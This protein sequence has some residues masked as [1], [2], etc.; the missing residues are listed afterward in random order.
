MLRAFTY[1]L[2]L[3]ALP[4]S[5]ANTEPVALSEQSEKLLQGDWCLS[6]TTWDILENKTNNTWSFL[7][8]R[9]Y[10][11]AEN[12]R[13]FKGQYEI[14]GDTIK[15]D[16]YRLV[17]VRI[18]PDKFVT[19]ANGKETVFTKGK[20][21]APALTFD[22]HM[23]MIKS[24]RADDVA[25]LARLLDKAG[26]PNITEPGDH[27]KNTP[28]HIAAKHD[29]RLAAELLLKRKADVARVDSASQTPLDVAV[30]NQSLRVAEAL[31]KSGA[32]ANHANASG[33]TSLM[34]A[35][36]KKNVDMVKLLLRYGA[37]PKARFLG[38]DNEQMDLIGYAR[39][40]NAGPEIL[41]LLGGK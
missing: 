30:Q 39:K 17:N 6:R 5:Q 22:E 2:L 19:G 41:M 12:P 25:A 7:P 14:D 32:D 27:Y 35:I 9:T 36:G 24:I 33:H 38:F 26:D 3:S 1:V 28:L 15:I 29:A 13:K 31:L 11:Y 8:G 16:F 4:V 21:A 34:R 37:N 10:E 40:S 23:E 18:Y 20:C